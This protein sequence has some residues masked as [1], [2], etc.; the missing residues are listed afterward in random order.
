MPLGRLVSQPAEAG[1]APQLAFNEFI[2]YQEVEEA[3]L[4][5]CEAKRNTSRRSGR[6]RR[7]P[8]KLADAAAAEAGSA[9]ALGMLARPADGAS[10]EAEEAEEAQ[11]EL[12]A[13]AGSDTSSRAW[14]SSSMTDE[15]PPRA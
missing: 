1:Q 11:S 4:R 5:R 7:V 12:Q 15:E 8:A 6:A 14:S 3:R 2:V 9:D 13:S 10:K